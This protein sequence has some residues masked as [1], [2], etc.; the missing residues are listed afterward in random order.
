[1][2]DYL[3]NQQLISESGATVSVDAV[4]EDGD[5]RIEQDEKIKIA[6][7]TRDIQQEVDDIDAAIDAIDR[8]LKD[9]TQ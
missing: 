9:K 8:I 5:G 1:M 7:E 4:K 2:N 3:K 6:T